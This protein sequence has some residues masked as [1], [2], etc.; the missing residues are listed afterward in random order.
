MSGT[1]AL[2]ESSKKLLTEKVPLSPPFSNIENW[3]SENLNVT[4]L[5]ITYE[6]NFNRLNVVFSNEK[7][8][9]KFTLETKKKYKT[10]PLSRF[11]YQNILKN[12]P[13]FAI[14]QLYLQFIHFN[15]LAINYISSVS[16]ITEFQKE[17]N[18]DSLW[19]IHKTAARRCVFFFYNENE[20]HKYN[21]QENKEYLVD[22]YYSF[23]KRNDE[24]NL[25][26][27]K[28]IYIIIDTKENLEVKYQ[29]SMQFYL[30]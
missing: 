26:N 7:D 1:I 27:K 6:A 30:R 13:G 22:Q 28:D 18:I 20:A 3:I 4:P 11:E 8:L 21:D 15:H 25:L 9:E 19:K 23:L 16:D 10:V 12:Y 29:G 5:N 14:E 17:L 24:F 2:Y